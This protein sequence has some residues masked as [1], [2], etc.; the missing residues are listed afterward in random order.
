[1]GE[2]KSRGTYQERKVEAERKKSEAEAERNSRK[3]KV[4]IEYTGAQTPTL[5]EVVLDVLGK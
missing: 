1:M 5:L 3:Q 4:K 2:A